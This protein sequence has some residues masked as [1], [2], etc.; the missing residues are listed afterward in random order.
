MAGFAGFDRSDYPGDAV[1]AWLEGNTNLLWCGYYLRGPSHP[2]QSWSG[3]RSLLVKEGWGLAPVYVGQETMGPG[4]HNVTAVQGSIDGKDACS[5][6]T[7]EGFPPGSFVYLD[8][9]NPDPAHQSAYAAAWIDAVVAGGF[10]PG[11]YTSFLDSPQIA[12]LRAGVRIWSFHVRTVSAHR[13]LGAT[14]PNPDPTTSGFDRAAMWQHDDAAIISC[15]AAPG[16]QLLV[17]LNSADSDDPSAPAAASAD[18]LYGK[19][20]VQDAAL[21]VAGTAST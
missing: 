4:S 6:M 14:F 20:G 2:N 3:K 21:D 10:G 17:D 18:L 5:R 13:V 12:R 7:A 1:M 11:V 19:Q 9:E 8:L 15:A 16:D